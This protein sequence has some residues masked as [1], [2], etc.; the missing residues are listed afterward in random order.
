[1]LPGSCRMSTTSGAPEVGRVGV[2][3]CMMPR[4]SERSD[5]LPEHLNRRRLKP[6][7]HARLQNA[8]ENLALL[9]DKPGL[10]RQGRD[11]R[12]HERD[13]HVESGAVVLAESRFG[14][15]D[16]VLEQRDRYRLGQ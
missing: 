16:P 11:V 13:R 6:F 15:S 1:M 5:L 8:I 4:S 9:T 14:Q 12:L 2:R 3:Y 10:S 7:E